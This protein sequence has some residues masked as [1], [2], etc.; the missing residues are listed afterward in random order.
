MEN[1]INNSPL[2]KELIIVFV[3]GFCIFSQRAFPFLLFSKKNPP[4]VIKFIQ[5]F[6]PPLVM[7][8][9]LVYCVKDVSFVKDGR[10]YPAEFVPS[11]ASVFVTMTL[12]LWRKNTLLS[13]LAGTVLYMLLSRCFV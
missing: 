5:K 11:F 6:I 1:V 10:I 4:P 13:I 7:A 8:C 9:L 12:Q 2:A 3:C